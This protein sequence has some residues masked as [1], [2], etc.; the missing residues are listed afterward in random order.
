MTENEFCF[1]NHYAKLC[2]FIGTLRSL[3]FN[4]FIG[5]YVLIC[6]YFVAIFCAVYFLY[7]FVLCVSVIIASFILYRFLGILTPLFNLK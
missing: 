2:H 1:I 3:K 5:K 4:D 6:S 7:S